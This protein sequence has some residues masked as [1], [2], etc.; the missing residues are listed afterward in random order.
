MKQNK[1]NQTDPFSPFL[2]AQRKEPSI[3]AKDMR[4]TGRYKVPAN[5]KSITIINKPMQVFSKA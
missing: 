3:F 4:F 1:N 2:W 5:A